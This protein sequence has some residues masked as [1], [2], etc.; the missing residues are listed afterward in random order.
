MRGLGLVVANELLNAH[1]HDAVAHN[2][3]AE[4]LSDEADVTHRPHL[5]LPL[6]V[7]LLLR[8]HLVPAGQHSLTQHRFER[9]LIPEHNQANVQGGHTHPFQEVEGLKIDEEEE[10]I[11]IGL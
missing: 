7:L 9:R 2:L 4:Q 8:C 1:V 6:H 3:L 11:C 10:R 5:G